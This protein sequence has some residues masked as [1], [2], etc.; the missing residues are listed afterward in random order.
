MTLKWAKTQYP[1]VDLQEVEFPYKCHE[2]G[3][4]IDEDEGWHIKENGK[5]IVVGDCCFSK[6][7]RRQNTKARRFIEANLLQNELYEWWFKTLPEVDRKHLLRKMYEDYEQ[8][9]A[10]VEMEFAESEHEALWTE[11]V[12][13]EMEGER[14]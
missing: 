6:Y 13:D 1:W 5:Y 12:V 2:C 7:L 14:L 8:D 10:Y 11:F 4:G 3:C 9:K